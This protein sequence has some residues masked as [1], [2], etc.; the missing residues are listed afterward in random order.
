MFDPTVFD[1][2]F[3][4]SESLD[5]IAAIESVVDTCCSRWVIEEY[6]ALA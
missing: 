5:P 4:P 1:W 6:I 2:V 3:A